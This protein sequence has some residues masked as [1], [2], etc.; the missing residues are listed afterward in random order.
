MNCGSSSRLVLRRKLADRGHAR[1]VHDLEH[2]LAGNV[3][4]V[5]LAVDEFPCEAAVRLVVVSVHHRPELVHLERLAV[6]ADSVLHEEH[7]PLGRQLDQQ[8]QQQVERK[9]ENEDENRHADVDRSVSPRDPAWTGHSGRAR[10][11]R[12][13]TPRCTAA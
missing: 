7:G 6:L 11:P 13:T 10:S 4:S 3:L 8:P 5:R 2:V 1:I 9:P 12:A